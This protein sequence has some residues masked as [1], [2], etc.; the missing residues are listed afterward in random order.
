MSIYRHSAKELNDDSHDSDRSR[1]GSGC[2][3][4]IPKSQLLINHHI[5]Y[6]E[7]VQLK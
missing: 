7:M 3:I 5:Y 6:H 1:I 2:N 4:I